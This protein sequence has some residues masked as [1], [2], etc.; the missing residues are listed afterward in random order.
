MRRCRR[1]PGL[2]S[3]APPSVPQYESSSSTAATPATIFKGFATK[4]ISR[5][6]ADRRGRQSFQ[7]K[8]RQSRTPPS[9]RIQAA[10]VYGRL[11]TTPRNDVQPPTTI[12]NSPLS[13]VSTR[14]TTETGRPEVS[15]VQAE[16]PTARGRSRRGG[17]GCWSTDY[18]AEL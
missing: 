18:A 2:S 5:G 9:N 16:P 12:S 10:S 4:C 8:V 17:Q 15:N 11:E 13:N 6:M 1:S 14:S 7:W 3:T